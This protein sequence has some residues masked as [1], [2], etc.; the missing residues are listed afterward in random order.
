MLTCSV[1]FAFFGICRHVSVCKRAG[2][3]A[4]HPHAF[5][6][7]FATH[8][9]EGGADLITVK[10]SLDMELILSPAMQAQTI[11]DRAAIQQ[12]VTRQLAEIR[13]RDDSAIF[14]P[15]FRSRQVAYELRRLQNIPEQRVHAVRYERYGCM[16]CKTSDR[17]HAAPGMCARC[18][19]RERALRTRI[20]K[21]LM[22]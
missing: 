3:D 12:K 5:R 10:P 9:L 16:I 20:L 14:E 1:F 4:T 7:T 8:M 19:G 22:A 18:Y 15:F 6:H 21:E 2:I 17:I 11:V 13:A